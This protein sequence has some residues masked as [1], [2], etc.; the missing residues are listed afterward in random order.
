M[1]LGQNTPTCGASTPVSSKPVVLKQRYLSFNTAIWIE[2]GYHLCTRK[3]RH[4]TPERVNWVQFDIFVISKSYPRHFHLANNLVPFFLTWSWKS[5]RWMTE[6]TSVKD[7]W[8]LPSTK[9][10]EMP[11]SWGGKRECEENKQSRK[12]ETRQL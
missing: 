4:Q 1:S 5:R 8:P 11:C 3:Y 9:V 6:Q 10:L 7:A 2:P 12:N